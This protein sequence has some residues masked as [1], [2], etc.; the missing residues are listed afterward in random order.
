MK[1]I[2]L[3][4]AVLAFAGAANAQCASKSQQS[5]AMPAPIVGS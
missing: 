2:V 1:V 3:T 5:T 4:A